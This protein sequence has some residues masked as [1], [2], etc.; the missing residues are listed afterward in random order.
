M[1]E[2]MS[3]LYEMVNDHEFGTPSIFMK[4]IFPYVLL[5][6]IVYRNNYNYTQQKHLS[7][8]GVH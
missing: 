7:I 6:M 1:Y 5:V 3:P 4:D 2:V 8:N